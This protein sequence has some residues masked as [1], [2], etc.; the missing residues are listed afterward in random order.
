MPFP[1]NEKEQGRP[2]LNCCKKW[3]NGSLKKFYVRADCSS[4]GG[5][6][7]SAP[8][9]IRPDDEDEDVIDDGGVDPGGTR[10]CRERCTR[11]Y[12]RD[13]FGRNETARRR[14]LQGCAGKTKPPIEDDTVTPGA[15]PCGA[16]GYQLTAE[17]GFAGGVGAGKQPW[18]G[19][20]GTER[21]SDW[22][23]H[24]VWDPS[25]G[26]FV[27]I[28]DP[29]G[30]TYDSVCRKG[31]KR[32]PDDSGT[33]WC[34]PSGEDFD[35]DGDDGIGGEFEFSEGLQGLLGRIMERANSLL[36]YP[37]GLSP[38][39]RQGV[40]NYAIESVKAGEGGQIR[41][42]QDLLARRGLLGSG[43]EIAE[44][45]RIKRETRGQE[46]RI[47]RELAIDDLDRRFS[48][49]MGTTGMVQSLTGTLMQGEQI[50]EILSGARRS[51]G[52]AAINSIIA[53]LLGGGG[54]QNNNQWLQQIF[55]GGNQGLEGSG[56]L[57][58]LPWLL[59]NRGN[60]N[61]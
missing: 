30:Q 37:R 23:G 10:G 56:I 6:I 18:E 60:Q 41:S 15:S 24:F 5:V 14:C 54:G 4:R 49:L 39:E 8:D 36:D 53:L 55:S 40:I 59:T 27:T 16:G 3:V 20:P 21:S 57:D 51:E 2:G 47:R 12:P 9:P 61:A 32:T 28:D 17:V 58:W 48:E 50:P 42:S 38:Q 25:K 7:C 45:G 33:T 11:L 13:R 52:Q 29:G 44:T 31:Y 26:A 1:D 34:C 46:T 35:G 19:V 22:E 43:I